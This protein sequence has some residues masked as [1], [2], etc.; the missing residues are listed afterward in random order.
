VSEVRDMITKVETMAETAAADASRTRE[1]LATF[2]K[3]S[4]ER[5]DKLHDVLKIQQKSIGQL[6]REILDTAE[7]VQD[8]YSTITYMA[9]EMAKY[10]SVHDTVQL[11]ELGVEDLVH[12]QL[13]PRLIDANTLT[14]ALSNITRLLRGQSKEPC[15]STAREIYE[16]RN[17]DYAAE[18]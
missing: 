2:T 6:Y 12:G 17:F 15:Y 5:I 1:G 8:E 14:A 4:N 11:L 18:A 9:I 3:L 10:V 13:T 16:S 7:L